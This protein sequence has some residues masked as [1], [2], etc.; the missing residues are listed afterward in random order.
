M[1]RG[2]SHGGNESTRLAKRSR[3]KRRPRRRRG[4]AGAAASIDNRSRVVGGKS[5]FL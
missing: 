1:H 4:K 2:D 3:A 5:P